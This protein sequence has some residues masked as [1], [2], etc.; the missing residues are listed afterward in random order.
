DREAEAFQV[1]ND[2]T[3][4]AQRRL[5]DK[6]PEEKTNMDCLVKERE[7]VHIGIKVG[8]NITV[9]GVMLLKRRK[10]SM[11]A[12]LRKLLKYKAWLTRR[13]PGTADVGLVYGRD[14]GK[15]V[16]VDGFVDAD[17]AKDPDKGRSIIGYLFMVH[18]CDVSLKATLQHV[19]ALSTTEAEY[20]TFTEAVKESIW[21]KGLLIEL[22]VNLRSV[23]VN[24]DNE[25]AIHLSR[26]AMFHD[27]G[28]DHPTTWL[29]VQNKSDLED[30]HTP[31]CRVIES[32]KWY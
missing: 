15:H 16:D 13:S 9:T 32:Y 3:A 21:L 31:G 12:N 27:V 10:E 4:V 5:E 26:N 8:A 1:S 20:M 14:Q 25:S 6:Q 18:G 19:V 17:Y 24:C 7:N 23:V 22:G 28:F 29:L 11:K 2:D 30:K